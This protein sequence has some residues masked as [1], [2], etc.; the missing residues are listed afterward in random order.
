MQSSLAQE[1]RK[2]L[3]LTQERLKEVLHYSPMTGRFRWRV[4]TCGFPAYGSPTGFIS[5]HT[6]VAIQLD[7]VRHYSHRLAWLYVHGEHPTG[8]VDHENGNRVDN[9]IANL[10]QCPRSENAWKAVRRNASPLTGAFRRGRKWLARII[11]NGSQYY[12]GS[13]DTRKEAAAAYRCAVLLL[14]GEFLLAKRRSADRAA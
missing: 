7:R 11:V 8:E 4:R 12:L 1:R 13:Y 10:K 6:T 9:R 3:S 14:R 2:Q 5:R